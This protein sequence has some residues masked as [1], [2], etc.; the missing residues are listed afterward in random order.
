MADLIIPVASLIESGSGS[1]MV[2]IQF[3]AL[4]LQFM[5]RSFWQDGLL[6]N[7]TDNGKVTTLTGLQI[8][9]AA[10]AALIDGTVC[11]RP[12]AT[13][14]TV[15][16]GGAQKRYDLVI[17]KR[18]LATRSFSIEIKEGIEGGT[19]PTLAYTVGGLCEFEL[20]TIEVAAGALAIYSG[21]ITNTTVIIDPR[22]NLDERFNA[23]M[24]LDFT[25][26]TIPGL[27]RIVR[28]PVEVS[29]KSSMPNW[30]VVYNDGWCEQG[31]KLSSDTNVVTFSK[32]FKDTSYSAY[33]KSPAGL[34]ASGGQAFF[35]NSAST[36]GLTVSY[37]YGNSGL[38]NYWPSGTMWRAEGYIN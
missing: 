25:N 11:K 21:D 14:L 35:I 3:S 10:V 34:V 7:I 19:K 36:T 9:V 17:I 30:Y 28:W 32:E 15:T 12:E 6:Q 13:T 27:G 16:Q 26:S 2:D 24:D 4:D 1:E 33:G 20:A 31:G 8:N 22:P 18:N 23:K 37:G 29:A 5:N 38:H